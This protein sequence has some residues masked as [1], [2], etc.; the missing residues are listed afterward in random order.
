VS[1][2]FNPAKHTVVRV[3]V[4]PSTTG[5]GSNERIFGWF[6]RVWYTGNPVTDF[7]GKRAEVTFFE[8]KEAATAAADAYD[9]PEKEAV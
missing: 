5:R 8:T 6:T 7:R 3:E 1:V 4:V 9:Y 2:R